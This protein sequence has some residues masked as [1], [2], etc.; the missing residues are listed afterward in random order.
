[1]VKKLRLCKVLVYPVRRNSTIHSLEKNF[2]VVIAAIAASK[3]R[4]GERLTCTVQGSSC[5]D[6]AILRQPP[7]LELSAL[8]DR[9]II[10][11]FCI[12]S[13]RWAAFRLFARADGFRNLF[14]IFPFTFLSCMRDPFENGV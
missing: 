4:T 8:G 10:Q 12:C 1:M 7:G 5:R 6:F 11:F 13:R 2:H 14:L 3:I 9:K